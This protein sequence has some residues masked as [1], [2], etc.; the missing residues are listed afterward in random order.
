[1]AIVADDNSATGWIDDTTGE[2]VSGPTTSD[3]A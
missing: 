1:M 2:A 3:T